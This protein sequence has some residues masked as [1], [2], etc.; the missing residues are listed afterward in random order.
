MSVWREEAMWS[1]HA[2]ANSA[3]IEARPS[4][5]IPNRRWWFQFW[6]PRWRMIEGVSQ[7]DMIRFAANLANQDARLANPDKKTAKNRE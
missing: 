1:I 2:A 5:L 3:D 6:K 4:Y 7:A